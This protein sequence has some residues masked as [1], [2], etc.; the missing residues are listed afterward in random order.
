MQ[1]VL[2]QTKYYSINETSV[3]RLFSG[4]KTYNSLAAKGPIIG[5]EFAGNNSVQLCQQLLNN[6]LTTKYQNL[7]RRILP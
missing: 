4:N 6:L 5:L 3:E 2:V 7:T 1:I